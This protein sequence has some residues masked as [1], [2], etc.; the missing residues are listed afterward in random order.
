MFPLFHIAFPLLIF[1][2]PRLKKNYR[3]NRLALIIG[4]MIPDIIDK[5]ILFS[6]LG[7]G[8]YFFHSLLFV[9]LSFFILFLITKGNKEIS[10]PFLIGM[11]F[12]LL[13]DW[14]GIPLF[15]PFIEYEFVVTDDAIPLWINTLLT[16]P[17]VQATEII[18]AAFLIF[19]IVNNRLYKSEDFVKYLKTSP[20]FPPLLKI[21]AKQE[22]QIV[23]D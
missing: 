21:E 4:S 11:L 18:G 12:H 1:E 17:I 23:E 13:L 9:F 16:D 19:I 14:P 15:Y 2:I 6:G 8:R 22:I 20:L 10:F 7:S 3:I 5:A